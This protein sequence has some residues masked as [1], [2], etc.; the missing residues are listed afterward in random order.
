MRVLSTSIAALGLTVG[1]L[2]CG[3]DDDN[4]ASPSA[5]DSTEETTGAPDA[6]D[7]TDGTDGDTAT[8]AAP[9]DGPTI[10]IVGFGFGDPLSVP[11][12]TSVT[13]VNDSLEAHTLTADDGSFSSGEL[14]PGASAVLAFDEPGTFTFHCAFHSSM[15]GSIT[16]TA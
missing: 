9:A 8:T 11:A 1:L 13:V 10:S 16:V 12:G 5:T 3:D 15:Q 2:A 6:T 7:A 4:T 14:A